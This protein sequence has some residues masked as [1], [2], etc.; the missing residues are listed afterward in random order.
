MDWETGNSVSNQ[1]SYVYRV[2]AVSP[3]GVSQWSGC[4][5]ADTPA[6]P[7]PEPASEPD[8]AL[9][10][11]SN[12]I[13]AIV[14]DGVSLSWDG[15]A[16][17]AES[18]T[19]YELARGV[20]PQA[21]SVSTAE[22]IAT[23]SASIGWV[24]S[25]ANEPGLAL[26]SYMVRALR[27]GDQSQWSNLAD[28]WV[29]NPEP[30]LAPEPEPDPASLAP[31]NL[32]AEIVDDEVRLSWHAPAQDAESVTGYEVE[33]VFEPEPGITNVQAIPT[34][35]VATVWTGHGAS[36]PGRPTRTGC[37]RNAPTSGA[38]WC[39]RPTCAPP[40]PPDR[41]RGRTGLAGQPA[42]HPA[43]RIGRQHPWCG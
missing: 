1:G 14:D 5:R 43:A 21:G 7:E 36:D 38:E 27:D 39:C 6:A 40:R 13:A 25:H 22:F 11:P 3:S 12:L 35:S 42:R 24:D 10:A 2:K 26:Y 30:T 20:A 23:G 9:L 31:A 17:D 29:E 41:G 18:V 19:G 37:G 16:Q 33:R 4:A 32:A 8:P 15:P 34:G 28:V